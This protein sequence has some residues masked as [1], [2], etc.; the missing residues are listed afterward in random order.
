MKYW[1]DP[2]LVSKTPII[3]TFLL[4]AANLQQLYRMWT[5]WTADGQSVTAWI[6]VNIALILW[7]NFYRVITPNEKFAIW[8]T[9]VGIAL[10]SI[11]IATVLFF[12]WQT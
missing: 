12:R 3:T 11:V 6:S 1:N 5:T 7:L 8:G 10:N 9:T 2:Y 4:E